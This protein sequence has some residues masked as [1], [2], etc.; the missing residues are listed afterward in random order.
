MECSKLDICIILEALM[1]DYRSFG[2]IHE[3]GGGAKTIRMM[4]MIT[5]VTIS[6][7]GSGFFSSAYWGCGV[8]FQIISPILG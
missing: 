2:P 5:P 4:T 1:P 7:V 6:V 3:T 8:E